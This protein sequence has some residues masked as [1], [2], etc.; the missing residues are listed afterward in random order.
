L[1]PGQELPVFSKDTIKEAL[2]EPPDVPD[3]DRR[4]ASVLNL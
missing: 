1:S 2:T 3:L 4:G